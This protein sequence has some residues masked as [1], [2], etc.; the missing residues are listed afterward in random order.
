MKDILQGQPKF[1]VPDGLRAHFH[2]FIILIFAVLI[3][4]SL[5]SLIF[6]VS[7]VGSPLSIN[8][9]VSIFRGQSREAE[10][11]FFKVQVLSLHT[12][13]LVTGFL[14]YIGVTEFQGLSFLH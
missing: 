6:S 8:T 7:A 14:L 9:W 5:G 2:R 4:V 11:T 1:V 3:I 13:V 10:V 12:A